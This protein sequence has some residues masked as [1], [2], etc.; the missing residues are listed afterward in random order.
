MNKAKMYIVTWYALMMSDLLLALIFVICL[1]LFSPNS[2]TI[3]VTQKKSTMMSVNLTSINAENLVSL[4][5]NESFSE[6]RKSLMVLR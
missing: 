6:S 2:E 3:P 4:N 5:T 1:I